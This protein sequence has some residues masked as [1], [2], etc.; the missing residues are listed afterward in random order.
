MKTMK[1]AGCIVAIVLAARV[2]MASAQGPRPTTGPNQQG[3]STA[4]PPPA[5]YQAPTIVRMLADGGAIEL[6][7]STK[8]AGLRMHFISY[9]A[10][11]AFSAERKCKLLPEDVAG[12]V[13]GFVSEAKDAVAQAK[14]NEKAAAELRYRSV[15]YGFN[16][17]TLFVTRNACGDE[18]AKKAME[19]LAELFKLFLK[20]N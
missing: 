6:V 12:Y 14:P 13:P 8:N 4:D 18:P 19:T 17:G 11:F 9:M 15:A 5:S 10:G 2:E 20:K 3:S 1:I 16:D 7:G